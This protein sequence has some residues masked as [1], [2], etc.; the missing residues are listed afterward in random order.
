MKVAHKLSKLFLQ[1]YKL[2]NKIKDHLF[3]AN[4]VKKKHLNKLPESSKHKKQHLKDKV[5]NSGCNV[6]VR[7]HCSCGALSV[8]SIQS[9]FSWRQVCGRAS[10]T[11]W[12]RVRSRCTQRRRTWGTKCAPCGCAGRRGCWLKCGSRGRGGWWCRRRWTR[13]WSSARAPPGWRKCQTGLT[14]R[15]WCGSGAS[16]VECLQL[17]GTIKVE[18]IRI[19]F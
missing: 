16:F 18:D 13:R 3:Y 19:A 5:S 9:E 14:P 15:R 11:G 6:T 1:T 4:E 12:G 2:F 7:A 17:K 10:G 8:Y